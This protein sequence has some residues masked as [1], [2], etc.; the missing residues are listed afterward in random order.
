MTDLVE[1]Q[2]RKTVIITGASRGIGLAIAKRIVE[3]HDGE[4]WLDTS[5]SLGTT[6]CFTLKAADPG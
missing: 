5:A 2:E 6:F 1:P 4:I 3:R